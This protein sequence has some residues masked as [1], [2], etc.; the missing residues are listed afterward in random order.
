MERLF[1]LGIF[2]DFPSQ[3]RHDFPTQKPTKVVAPASPEGQSYGAI[4]INNPR[5][6]EQSYGLTR[7]HNILMVN[8]IF[9]CMYIS[10]YIYISIDG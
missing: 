6:S 3:F 4:G 8:T 9:I 10:V 7:N 5:S 1:D 2:R